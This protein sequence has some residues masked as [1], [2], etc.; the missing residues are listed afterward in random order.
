MY[1][2]LKNVYVLARRRKYARNPFTARSPTQIPAG[3]D[4]SPSSWPAVTREE[5]EHKASG[6]FRVYSAT[7]RP[8]PLFSMT[9]LPSALRLSI[10]LSP[11]F[12]PL[13]ML[14]ARGSRVYTHGQ[15]ADATDVWGDVLLRTVYCSS[16]A[17]TGSGAT[18]DNH[19][20]AQ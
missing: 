19:V 8:Y 18:Y 1:S 20:I 14:R 15:C 9:R 4:A 2:F 10:R 13:R 3:S 11:A 16:A 5:G 12:F 17:A 7:V 6:L